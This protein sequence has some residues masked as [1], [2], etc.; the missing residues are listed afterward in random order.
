MEL[1]KLETKLSQI[2]KNYISIQNAFLTHTISS[3]YEDISNPF[4]QFCL[5]VEQAFYSLSSPLKKIINNEFFYQA[6]QGWWKEIYNAHHFKQLRKVAIYK[7]ME[8][9]YEQEQ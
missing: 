3:K 1:Q 2:A 8:A 5:G 9:Y 7:F 4:I 6:Y